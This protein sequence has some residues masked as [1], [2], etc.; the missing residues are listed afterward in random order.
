MIEGFLEK[1]S[2][3]NVSW[4]SRYCLMTV[5]D[6]RYYYSAELYHENVDNALGIIPLKAIYTILPLNDQEQGIRIHK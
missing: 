2:D 1:K 6:F 4:A 5:R 3:A